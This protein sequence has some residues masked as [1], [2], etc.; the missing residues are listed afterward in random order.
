MEMASLFTRLPQSCN[1][2]SAFERASE[3][4]F[5]VADHAVAASSVRQVE[6]MGGMAS[7]Q[8]IAEAS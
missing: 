2:E 1:V 4:T 8:T 5:E 6:A 3:C 7:D